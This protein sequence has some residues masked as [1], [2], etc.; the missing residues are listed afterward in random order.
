MK[1]TG[2]AFAATS[3][4][5]GNLTQDNATIGVNNGAATAIDALHKIEDTWVKGET[6]MDNVTILA[7]LSA[8]N[9]TTNQLLPITMLEAEPTGITLTEEAKGQMSDVWFDLQGRKFTKKPTVKGLY[10]VGNSKIV[11][12]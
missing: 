4:T 5:A 10:I 9:A 11:I 7:I 12:D 8:K 2:A 1:I 3:A 6:T